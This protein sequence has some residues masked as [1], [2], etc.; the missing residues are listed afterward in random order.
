MAEKPFPQKPREI[1]AP[2]AA[3]AHARGELVLVDVREGDERV[4][5][6]IEGSRH[7]PFGEIGDRLGE[8]PAGKPVGFVCRAGGRNAAAAA[9]VP[10]FAAMSPTSVAASRGPPPACLPTPPRTPS[11]NGEQPHDLS[12]D[13]SR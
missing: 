11:T 7:I 8:L 3:E 1:S 10:P 9:A 12:S 5:E 4:Q 2:E 6:H 13:H